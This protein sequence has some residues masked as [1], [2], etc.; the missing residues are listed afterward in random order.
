MATGIPRSARL[1][2]M[3]GDKADLFSIRLNDNFRVHLQMVQADNW[4]A[5]AVGSHKAM[6]HG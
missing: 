2:K 4:E 6:G 3:K 5:V 1:E